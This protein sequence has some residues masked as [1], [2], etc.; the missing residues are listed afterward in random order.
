MK[1]KN[2]IIVGNGF[3]LAHNLP[4]GYADFVKHY[5]KEKTLK[6]FKDLVKKVAHD[7]QFSPLTDLNIDRWYLFENWIEEICRY[8]CEQEYIESSSELPLKAEENMERA[9]LLFNK[10][11]DLLKKYLKEIQKEYPILKRDNLIKEFLLPNTQ[12]ISFNYTN[13]PRFYTKNVV[14][15]H[16]SIDDDNEVVFGC[17]NDNVPEYASFPF[18]QYEKEPLKFCLK[19]RRFLNHERYLSDFDLDKYMAE[20]SKQLPTIFSKKG[21]WN[22]PEIF[23]DGKLSYDTSSASDPLK[24]FVSLNEDP[25]SLDKYDRFKGIEKIVIMGHGLESDRNFFEQVSVKV[26]PT[27]KEMKIFLYEGEDGDEISR[28]DSFLKK[29]FGITD[30]THCYY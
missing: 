24:K 2:L 23:T 11:A 6:D 20:L 25:V 10:I 28:K 18:L 17:A 4:T 29:Q 26:K 21:G 7:K 5:G 3:D 1:L 15:I 27:I 22:F 8:Y 12:T 19:Y 16:G 14:Y 13:T 9:T 30:I